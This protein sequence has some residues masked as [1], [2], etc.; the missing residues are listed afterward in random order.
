MERASAESDDLGERH[1]ITDF[2]GCTAN[3]HEVA[4]E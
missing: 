3:A 2:T 4:R 1:S